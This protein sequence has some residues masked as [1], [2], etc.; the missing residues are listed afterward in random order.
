MRIPISP[1]VSEDGYEKPKRAMIVPCTGGG[2]RF[3]TM[4]L[5]NRGTTES[6]GKIIA[7]NL[8]ELLGVEEPVPVSFRLTSEWRV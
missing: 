4:G 5:F 1:V 7:T 3:T 6:N 8:A 2:G